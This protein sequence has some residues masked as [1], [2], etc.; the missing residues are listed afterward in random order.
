MAVRLSLRYGLSYRDVEKPL[1]ERGI[2]V[3]HLTIYR[4]LQRFTPLAAAVAGPYRQAARNRWFVDETYVKVAGRWRHVYRAVD[5]HGQIIDVLVSARR[6]SRSA[7]RFFATALR[8]FGR[9]SRDSSLPRFTTLS[10]T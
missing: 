5:Q 2:Q 1:G 7:R 6:D 8:R 4:W 3:D 10:G 9:R